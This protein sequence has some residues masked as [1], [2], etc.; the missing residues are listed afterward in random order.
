[1]SAVILRVGMLLLVAAVVSM[2]ARRLRLPYTVGLVLAG[3][4]LAVVPGGQPIQLTRDL[5][6]TALLPPLIFEAAIQLDWRLL[7]RDLPVVSLL[8]T[9]GVL[10]SASIVASGVHFVLG[11]SW[12]ASILIAVML[13]ATDPVAVIATFKSLAIRGRLQALVE[14]E[15][16]FNDGTAA[17]LFAIA[18]AAAAGQGMSGIAMAQNFVVTIVGGVICGLCVAFAA[19]LMA[20]RTDDHLVEITFTTIAAYGSFLLAE[21][22]HFSGVLSTLAAGVLLANCGS[23]GELTDKGRDSIE[24]FWEYIAF[25]ANS[26]VFL[27]IGN[28]LVFLNFGAVGGA[29]L[30]TSTLLL[31]GRA[32][33]VYG[34]CA[35]LVKSSIK[36][37]IAFQHVLIWGGLRGALALALALGLPS[38]FEHRQDILNVTF[39]VVALSVVFQGI[40]MPTLL[41][42]LGL[43]SEQQSG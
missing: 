10:I 3:L 41:K 11:W 4:G 31:V 13:S 39:A 15:S 24:S 7:R 38:D 32:A 16:L 27:L 28:A 43:H 20:G 22:L 14:S 36:V 8:A 33:A 1:M 42:R 17:V 6:F 21:S 12:P 18:L 35:A 40:T 37:P 29:V 30:L 19:L 25:L 23:V 26:I 9:L 5:I 2:L 34:C